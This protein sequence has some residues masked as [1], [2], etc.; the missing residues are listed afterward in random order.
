MDDISSV[1]AYW[2]ATRH[3][4]P[5]AAPIPPTEENTKYFDAGAVKIGLEGRLLTTEIVNVAHSKRNAPPTDETFDDSGP[6]IHVLGAENGYEY[7]RFDCFAK[8][9][10]YH[11]LVEGIPGVIVIWYDPIA[12]GEMAPWACGLLRN[13]LPHLLRS[14]GGFAEADEAERSP[15]SFSQAMDQVEALLLAGGP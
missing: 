8:D 6:S 15:E 9:P 1:R 4:R 11:F 2:T 3:F 7:L 12:N 10:H 5:G 13:Q 14:A